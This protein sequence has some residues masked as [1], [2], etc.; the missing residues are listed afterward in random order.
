MDKE[1]LLKTNPLLRNEN[2]L[3]FAITSKSLFFLKKKNPSHRKFASFFFFKPAT[4]HRT[5]KSRDAPEQINRLK[6]KKSIPLFPLSSTLVP[7]RL[8]KA[9]PAF[10]L[11]PSPE[12]NTASGP[13]GETRAGLP[14]RHTGLSPSSR[15]LAWQWRA[16]QYSYVAMHDTRFLCVT[17]RV[18][19]I[20]MR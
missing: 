12:M 11:E 16:G 19:L 7:R 4:T 9:P 6:K 1:E 17:S 5:Q 18:T 13:K 2:F 20:T 10:D 15:C 8:E 14:A 3:K